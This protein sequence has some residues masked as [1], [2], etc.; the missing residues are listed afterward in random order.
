MK[1]NKRISKVLLSASMLA[2]IACQG[3]YRTVILDIET[4]DVTKKPVPFVEIFINDKAV[5]ITDEN[6]KHKLN[7]EK[8]KIGENIR[9]S[10]NPTMAGYH[11]LYPQKR[12]LLIEADSSM[13][14][15]LG[16]SDPLLVEIKEVT[17]ER[18]KQPYLFVVEGEPNTEI[19]IENEPIADRIKDDGYAIIL[20]EAT[21]GK[22]FT[23]QAGKL[24]ASGRFSEGQEI[25]VLTSQKQEAIVDSNLLSV[26]NA[27]AEATQAEPTSAQAETEVAKEEKMPEPVKEV[28]K[29]VA[30]AKLE[31]IQ[32]DEESSSKPIKATKT[33]VMPKED[34]EEAP[35]LKPIKEKAMPIKL[36]TDTEDEPMPK[37]TIP[38]MKTKKVETVEEEEN[39]IPPPSIGNQ[40]SG[41]QKNQKAMPVEDE[42]DF[43]PPPTTSKSTVL[44]LPKSQPQPEPAV[45]L[46]TKN[47]ASNQSSGP[48]VQDLLKKNN[49]PTNTASS[50]SG[51]TETPIEDEDI[52]ASKNTKSS[53]PVMGSSASALDNVPKETV[54]AE[55]DRISENYGRTKVLRKQDIDYLKQ[56]S[57]NHGS[58]YQEANRILG[59]YYFSIKETNQ[60]IACLEI[61]TKQGKYKKDPRVMLSLAQAYASIGKH[62]DGLDVMKKVEPMLNRLGAERANAHQTYAEM[63][64]FAYMSVKSKNPRQANPVYLDN[65]IEQWKKYTQ[66][67]GD[68]GKAQKQI[69]QLE[70]LKADAN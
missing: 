12:E 34:T 57:T 69:E 10:F 13:M 4:I 8:A 37:A 28:M 20:Y 47:N 68:S 44:P 16:K 59:E 64:K 30:V 51:P 42:E 38:S 58:A 1:L 48:S 56:V 7:Y 32:E 35:V 18:P 26:A 22:T 11:E 15:M 49:K 25:Y 43:I 67:G 9:I 70:S 65:A 55:V 2:Q 50:G 66:V 23:I 33:A 61:A 29:P 3:E 14:A 60:Q 45:E 27:A 31:P 52:M 6:G 24:A 36:N 40:K 46:K 53:T 17:F 19:L 54:S 62:Q 41:N 39:M 5:A 63:Y 21:P